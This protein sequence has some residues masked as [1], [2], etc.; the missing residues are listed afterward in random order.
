MDGIDG[1]IGPE[2]KKH[3]YIRAYTRRNED[4]DDDS[5]AYYFQISPHTT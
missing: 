3:I 5:Y 4:G 1:K 2:E